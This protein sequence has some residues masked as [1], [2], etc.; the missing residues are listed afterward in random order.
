MRRQIN[1]PHTRRACKRLT[2]YCAIGALGAVG[3]IGA[4][5]VDIV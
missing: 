2:E 5:G 4:L 1:L 3:A